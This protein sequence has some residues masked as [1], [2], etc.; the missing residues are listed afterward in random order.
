MN[1][2]GWLIPVLIVAVNALCIIVQWNGLPE[3]LPA[4]FDLQGNASG[5]MSRSVLPMYPLA[6]AAVFYSGYADIWK[7]AVFHVG[8]TCYPP[9][10][11]C[12]FRY[13]SC[14]IPQKRVACLNSAGSSPD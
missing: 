8:R 9:A 6:S 14:Q 7:D 4:H 2:P 5:S 11:R 1:K 12:R 10:C 3:L 13:L